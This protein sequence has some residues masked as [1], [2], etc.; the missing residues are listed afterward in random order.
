MKSP[1]EQLKSI[2]PLRITVSGAIGAGKSTFAKRLAQELD[3]PR[4]YMGQVM[5]EEAARRGMTLDAFNA[6]LEVDDQVDRDVDA[7]QVEKGRELARAVFE[8]RTS[9]HFIESPDVTLF[10]TVDPRVAAERIFRDD[11]ALRDQ[12]GSV[13]EIMAANEKR[14]ANELLRYQTYYGI[15][16]YDLD[17]YD[18]VIDTSRLTVEEVFQTATARIADFLAEKS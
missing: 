4:M 2:S 15:N 17:N 13:E 8:G 9:W 3:I 16:V 7:M 6:L 14:K 10:F 11:S 12:Y 5:R 18:L 1:L